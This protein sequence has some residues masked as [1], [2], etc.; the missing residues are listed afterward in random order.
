MPVV[1]VEELLQVGTGLFEAAGAPPDI[2]SL[3]TE[4]LLDANLAGHDS[5]GVIRITQYLQQILDGDLLPAERP[6]IV[7]DGPSA[8]QV[9]GRWGFGQVAARFC[10]EL[11]VER[12]K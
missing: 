2:A 10:T 8:I 9:D 3:V 5:H 4:S 12:A 1:P 11:A 7:R 6:Q